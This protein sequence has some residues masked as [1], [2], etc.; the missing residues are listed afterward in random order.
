MRTR[1]L[2]F[3]LACGLTACFQTKPTEVAGGGGIE[4]TDGQIVSANGSGNGSV[5]GVRVRLVPDAWNPM[6][7]DGFPD[8]LAATTDDSGR[9]ALKGVVPGHYNLEAYAPVDGSRLF[10]PGLALAKTTHAGIP[11]S[12]LARPGRLRLI[13]EGSHFGYLF[14]PGTTI[15][16]RILTTEIE[17]PEIVIDSL[18]LGTLGPIRWSQSRADTVGARISDSL[19]IFSDSTSEWTVLSAWAHHGVWHINTTASGAALSG[20]AADVGAFPL[21]IRLA[22]PGFD[23]SQAA[24]DGSDIRFSAADGSELA[25]QVERWDA[26]AG[27]AEIWVKVPKIA[28]IDTGGS[29][30]MH[31]GNPA[32]GSRSSGPAVFGG[33]AG[34]AAVWHLGE[35][36]VTSPGGYRDAA[37]NG[38]HGTAAAA[39]V[40]ASAEGEIGLGQKFD[41]LVNRI[42]LGDAGVL[43]P[44]ASITVAAWFNPESWKGGNRRILQKGIGF[45]QYALAGF[46]EDSVEWRLVVGAT[47]YM[48]RAQ[49][50][51]LAEWHLLQGTYDGSKAILYLDG[52]ALIQ[53]D[54][55]G[56]MGTSA[57][58]LVIGHAPTGPDNQFFQGA[59]DEVSI[60]PQARSA[61]WLKLSYE[62]QRQDS[63]LLRLEI[64]K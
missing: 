55:S 62:N 35:K 34:F 46:G 23:F 29:F 43:D 28:G 47:P 45:T 3:L 17:A 31:W 58:S 4:T 49:A 61:D 48:L 8:S 56:A 37:A 10:V 51:P 22:A 21:L 19:T 6:A 63:K 39:A 7:H 57:D 26:P 24:V 15:L 60:S 38:L 20:D 27:K 64:L 12:L 53:R 59:L 52:Q 44:M 2:G 18:P 41:G 54:I 25:Y 40:P 1:L 36:T 9:Y 14:I 16:R 11:K 50:P 5:K 42:Q 33:D 32:A 30:R 13:W